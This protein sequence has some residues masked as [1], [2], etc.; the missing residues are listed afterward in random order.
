VKADRGASIPASSNADSV[1]LV[2]RRCTV[3]C[4]PG[5]VRVAHPGQPTPR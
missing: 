4:R 3:L 1:A 5:R 2:R